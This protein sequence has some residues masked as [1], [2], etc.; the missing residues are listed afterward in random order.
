M[1]NKKIILTTFLTTL[2]LTSILSTQ[3]IYAI[4]DPSVSDLAGTTTSDWAGNSTSTVGTTTAVAG[5]SYPMQ[6]KAFYANGR[7]WV[8]YSDATNLV[9]RTSTDGSTWSGTTTVRACTIGQNFSIYFDGTYVH[10]AHSDDALTTGAIYYR[11]G[12]PNSD[13]T[14][15]WSAAEQTAVAANASYQERYPNIAVDSDGHAIITFSHIGTGGGTV[16]LPIVTRNDNVDGTWSTTAGYP[17]QLS[18][19][20]AAYVTSVVPLTS[21]KYLCMYCK[22]NAI[23]YARAWDGT[24]FTAEKS[25]T[26]ILK[27]TQSWSA[28]NDGDNVHIAMYDKTTTMIKYTNYTY[29]TNLFSAETTIYANLGYPVI[30]MDPHN[31]VL[32]V[33]WAGSPGANRI[34][35][36]RCVSGVWDASQTDWVNEATDTLTGI[37]YLTCFP[38]SYG[39]RMGVMYLTKAASPYSVKIACTEEVYNLAG[40]TGPNG[41]GGLQAGD[42]TT[43]LAFADMLECNLSSFRVGNMSAGDKYEVYFSFDT[44]NISMCFVATG[45]DSGKLGLFYKDSGSGGWSAG[46][47]FT[48]AGITSGVSYSSVNDYVGFKLTD[49]SGSTRGSVKFVVTRAYLYNTVGARGSQVISIDGYTYKGSSTSTNPG[50]D[51]GTQKDRCPSGSNTAV[52]SLTGG[53]LPEFPLGA[54]ILAMPMMI[55]YIC[56]RRRSGKRLLNVKSVA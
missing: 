42:D 12:T 37:A 25:T 21:G 19:T 4:T 16:K 46:E 43:T 47:A 3:T 30:S 28:I 6:R 13:G 5:I 38:I 11:R 51:G 31:N 52:Y 20:N 14:I 50:A 54:L 53:V 23:L 40:R 1:L 49:A 24:A 27:D 10:Y 41:G 44:K 9:F 35:Y 48:Q 36:K 15:T 2:L 32:Y 18:T 22:G 45:S 17:K 33:F 7:F 8:F 26:S 56:M 39:M 55:V 29:A 34:Y